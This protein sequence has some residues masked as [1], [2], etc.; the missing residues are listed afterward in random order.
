MQRTLA[1]HDQRLII[2]VVVV[3]NGGGAGHKWFH[4]AAGRCG[5][6]SAR[7]RRARCGSHI[8]GVIIIRGAGFQ[9]RAL[10]GWRVATDGGAFNAAT[11]CWYGNAAWL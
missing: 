2:G 7:T 9:F 3:H 10:H 8:D 1:V 11:S 4:I 6:A 5:C